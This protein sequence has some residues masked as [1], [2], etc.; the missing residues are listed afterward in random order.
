MDFVS[1][2]LNALMFFDRVLIPGI[3]GL[4]VLR[5]VCWEYT[6]VLFSLYIGISVWD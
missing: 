6:T 1:N 2:A 3:S 4:D 5:S